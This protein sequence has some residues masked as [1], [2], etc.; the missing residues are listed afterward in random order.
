MNAKRSKSFPNSWNPP[1]VGG[2]RVD[3]GWDSKLPHLF[4]WQGPDDKSRL[5]RLGQ[6]A[7]HRKGGHDFGIATCATHP[8]VAC[9]PKRLL[10]RWR[11]S[12]P[13]SSRG[14]PTTSGSSRT[15]TT[16]RR[17]T[18]VLP[19]L[20]RSGTPAGGGPNCGRSA[21]CP[22]RSGTSRSGS[23]TRF[24][25]LR[26][27]ITG[28]WAQHPVST[29]PLLAKKRCRRS[30]A[31]GCREAGH[32]GSAG[33]SR[34]H[35]SAHCI[36]PGVGCAGLQRRTWLRHQLLQRSP[37]LRHLDAEAGLDRAGTRHGRGGKRR[38]LKTLAALAST[39]SPSV[40]VFNPTLQPRCETVEVEL[41]ES[42]TESAPF[43]V[44]TERPRRP[45]RGRHT[46]FQDIGD[47][48]DGIRGVPA[49]PEATQDDRRR[50]AAEPHPSIENAFY[51]V[52]F[53]ADGSIS[54]I[55]DKQLA[56]AVGRHL[57]TVPVQPV[58]LHAR[59]CT[60]AFLRPRQRSS[61]S[62]PD[63]WDRP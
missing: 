33:R 58:R 47:S 10:R 7:L 38:A 56:A 18:S 32:P 40:F 28:G 29:P 11:S 53:G 16:T 43:A 39:E 14:I 5:A 46:A 6:P 23:A 12:L 50:R 2:A 41:P 3:V 57:G 24:P 21:I 51:R 35:L 42:C 31:A 36:A 63:R 19:R 30:A 20:P 55:F 34:L 60:R 13:C 4:Y 52:T 54:G 1:T 8:P 22:N 26:G 59:T 37:R 15:T 45:P 49:L 9:R 25:T 61:R 48:A 44:R 62:R 17:P 27:D